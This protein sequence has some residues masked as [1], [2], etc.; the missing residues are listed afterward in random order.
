MVLA[1]TSPPCQAIRIHLDTPAGFLCVPSDT[2]C[3]LFRQVLNWRWDVLLP[4]GD[5]ALC[6][7]QCIQTS[8]DPAPDIGFL[9]RLLILTFPAAWGT[10]RVYPPCLG[11]DCPS[12]VLA[13]RRGKSSRNPPVLQQGRSC[14]LETPGRKSKLWSE[15]LWSVFWF[16]ISGV[17]TH[18]K[19]NPTPFFW[20]CSSSFVH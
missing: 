9:T 16:E 13:W 14:W 20:P 15:K 17:I 6:K 8:L 7:G 10:G 11:L 18:A 4:R 2:L 3:G 5:V 1:V 19:T 12:Q